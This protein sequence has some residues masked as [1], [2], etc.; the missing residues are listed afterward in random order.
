MLHE[1]PTGIIRVVANLLFR[2]FDRWIATRRVEKEN[3]ELAA[4]NTLLKRF[5]VGF[6]ILSLAFAFLWVSC[7]RRQVV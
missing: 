6:A 5:A 4:R 3:K 1:L 7:Y 2:A